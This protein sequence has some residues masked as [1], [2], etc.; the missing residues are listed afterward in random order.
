[1]TIFVVP[2][3]CLE[4]RYT[5]QWF[6]AIP[7][8][9]RAE[10]ARRG[11][12]E[13]IETIEGEEV[14][15][16]TSEGAFLDFSATNVYKGTQVAAIARLFSQGRVTAGDKFLVTDAW[17]FA[18]TAIRYMSELMDVPV[19]VHSVWHAGSYD[20]TDILGI[21]MNKTWSL[22][23]ERAW[24]YASDANYFGTE[25]HRRMFLERLGIP[26][27]HHDRAIRSGQPHVQAVDAGQAYFDRQDRGKTVVFPHRLNADKQPAIFRDLIR[28]LPW[29]WECV[30]TQDHRL[31]KG[32]L[33]ELFGRSLL[34]FSCALHENLGIGVMEGLV[35]GCVPAV[36]DRASYREMYDPEFRYP[37][38]WTA[39]WASYGQHRG[40]LVEFLVGLMERS[41]EIRHS[42]L[43]AQ[44]QAIEA[45]YMYPTAML[46]RVLGPRPDVRASSLRPDLHAA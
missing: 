10:C 42:R 36:P 44:K 37:S 21:K 32:E 46:N 18:I 30:V 25:F 16:R 33:Y 26:A 28:H 40:K 19:E 17:N 3:E 23:Q 5:K 4:Q 41:D 6:E 15:D 38:E 12:D 20:P 34:V 14:A 45:G 11:L 31:S 35:C 2:L 13:A 29:D 27:E 39:D 8:I 22:D 24:F 9:L 1:M 7:A 43:I